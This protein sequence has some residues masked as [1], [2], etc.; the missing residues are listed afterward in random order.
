MRFIK[1][2]RQSEWSPYVGGAPLGLLAVLSLWFT[3]RLLSGSGGFENV[4]GSIVKAVSPAAADNVYWKFVQPPGISWGV[5]SI[6]GI[7]VGALVAALLGRTFKWRLVSDDQWKQVF[8]PAVWKRWLALFLGAIVL[9]YGAGIA[10]GCTS[11][12]AISGG[13]QLTPSAFLFMGGMF[14]SGIPTAMILY[15]KRY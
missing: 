12:L 8:G 5:V 14:A 9:E 11:G 15:R 3:D 2:L 6:L 10:G 13:L 1:W 7:M 4:G